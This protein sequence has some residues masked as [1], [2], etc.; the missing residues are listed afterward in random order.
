MHR[1]ENIFCIGRDKA[2]SLWYEHLL[3]YCSIPYNLLKSSQRSLW[4]WLCKMHMY[5]FTV[6][7]EGNFMERMEK[8]HINKARCFIKSFTYEDYTFFIVIIQDIQLESAYYIFTQS[9]PLNL[10][11]H[12]IGFRVFANNLFLLVNLLF[13][14]SLFQMQVKVQLAQ[15][16]FR[17]IAKQNLY[18]HH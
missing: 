18:F 11:N 13:L 5:A 9:T 2:D 7:N 15:I 4:G 10:R 16:D 8:T 14:I 3:S 1:C 6:R 17:D 12:K